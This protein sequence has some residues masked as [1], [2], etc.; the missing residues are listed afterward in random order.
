[1]KNDPEGLGAYA[2]PLPAKSK[3]P[4]WTVKVSTL[5]EVVNNK[6]HGGRLKMNILGWLAIPAGV[7][8]SL[9]LG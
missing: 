8:F 5:R 2:L 9:I 3:A 1:M 4:F 6:F 7:Q